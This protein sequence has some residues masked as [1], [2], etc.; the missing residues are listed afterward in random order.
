MIDVEAAVD[1]LYREPL[2]R[3]VVERNDLV[4]RLRLD[5]RTK[6]AKWVHALGK[7]SVAAWAVNQL[8]WRYETDLR[9]LLEAG[10]A[11][12]WAQ[13]ALMTGGDRATLAPAM[14]QQRALLARLS[15]RAESALIEAGH[16]AS[17]STLR[18]V[19][20]T[21][22]ALAAYG[23][24]GEQQAGRLIQPLE[25]PGFEVL[26]ALAAS[27]PAQPASLPQAEPLHALAEVTTARKAVREAEA[28]ATVHRNRLSNAQRA[29]RHAQSEAERREAEAVEVA[30]A[31][32]RARHRADRAQAE[33]RATKASLQEAEGKLDGI[34]RRLAAARAALQRLE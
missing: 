9:M 25:A 13:H 18:A 23:T 19:Q 31:A 4:K 6:D 30:Q 5:G 11:V 22:E 14:T 27:P 34:E 12:R 33:A 28:N 10:D 16:A 1:A 3:F 21:L 20:S 32:L 29:H 8:R 15:E 7:P 26:L 2:K 17:Q 24:Q